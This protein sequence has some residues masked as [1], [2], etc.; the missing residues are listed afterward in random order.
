[1]PGA[2]KL[3]I[4]GEFEKKIY[5]DDWA[6]KPQSKDGRD[7]PAPKD[8]KFIDDLATI[9]SFLHP[10]NSLFCEALQKLD[11]AMI[12]LFETRTDTTFNKGGKI[13]PKSF[14]KFEHGR[15][16]HN[17]ATKHLLTEV[18]AVHEKD[19][20]FEGVET[21]TGK[22]VCFYNN[23]PGDEFGGAIKSQHLAKDYVGSD[24]GQYTHR[25][26]W[27]C[28]GVMR[29]SLGLQNKVM[30][31]IFKSSG[32]VWG[33]VFDRNAS[34]GIT[35]LDKDFR[36]P[37]MMNPWIAGNHRYGNYT[38]PV[39]SAFLKS[40]IDRVAARGWTPDILRINLAAKLFPDKVKPSAN[41]RKATKEENERE[42]AS[43]NLSA[44]ELELVSKG[45]QGSSY[46]PSGPGFASF[47]GGKKTPMK[48]PGKIVST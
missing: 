7:L 34:E 30:A 18:L 13:A 48:S 11:D 3:S 40:R 15:S 31:N 38:W 16:E 5:K 36:R 33:V 2:T 14:S 26:Q 28:A 12:K 22:C 6:K 43:F 41:Y 17:G 1:M 10:E 35:L 23:L 20:G 27:Y 32:R 45:A 46:D 21:A 4:L 24:H 42:L 9:G 25:I 8:A 39:L 37:E 19:A 47:A 44:E 29:E